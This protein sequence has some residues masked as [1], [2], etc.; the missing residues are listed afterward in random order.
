MLDIE[1]T[2]WEDI[3]NMLWVQ[4][5]LLWRLL[6]CK[7]TTNW[8][9]N[10]SLGFR[11]MENGLCKY[12]EMWQNM[13]KINKTKTKMAVRMKSQNLSYF[14]QNK[15]FKKAIPASFKVSSSTT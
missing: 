7:S 3:S 8:K 13:D 11:M 12:G 2:L 4:M 10:S 1:L 6:L 14:H 15:T 5:L 9:N